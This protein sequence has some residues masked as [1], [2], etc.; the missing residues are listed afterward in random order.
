MIKRF[1]A[2]INGPWPLL[3]VFNLLLF[4]PWML[5]GNVLAQSSIENPPGILMAASDKGFRYMTGGIGLEE[6][7]IMQRWG[8]DYNL[9]L[10]FAELSGDYLSDVRIAMQDQN[11]K[12]VINMTTNGPWL[13][14]KLPAGTYDV[15]ASFEGETR[16]IENLH[17]PKGDRVTRLLHWDLD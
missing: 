17:L 15:K 12:N 7:E 5:A 6:R 10:T 13:Y 4:S 1:E 2:I 16:Q 3:L 8:T 14:V 9:K 11:G